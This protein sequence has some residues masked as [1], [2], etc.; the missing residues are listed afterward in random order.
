MIPVKPR[1]HHDPAYQGIW[2][3]RTQTGWVLWS[4]KAKY[5]DDAWFLTPEEFDHFWET[6]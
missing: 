6:V 1:N 4:E 2:A 3:L 5:E